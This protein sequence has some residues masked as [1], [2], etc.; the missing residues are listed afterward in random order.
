M[1]S[2]ITYLNANGFAQLTSNLYGLYLPMFI[3]IIL[4]IF[5]RKSLISKENI[6]LFTLGLIGCF[7]L[8]Y[9][10]TI[11]DFNYINGVAIPI[12]YSQ[13]HSVNVFGILYILCRSLPLGKKIEMNYSVVWIGSF[14]TIWIVDGWYALTEFNQGWFADGIGGAGILDGLLLTPIASV[15]GAYLVKKGYEIQTKWNKKKAII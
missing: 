7:I 11:T 5:A 12:T 1:T 9:G 10:K 15:I 3:T 2:L 14:T 13:F 8:S 6:I 4:I